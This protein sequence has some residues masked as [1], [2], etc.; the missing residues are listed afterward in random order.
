MERR[1]RNRR[2]RWPPEARVAWRFTPAA[3]LEDARVVSRARRAGTPAGG[4]F[5]LVFNGEARA[6]RAERRAPRA[7]R[8]GGGAASRRG[9]ARAETSATLPSGN[10][11]RDDVSSP[12]PFS[13]SAALD[14]ATRAT[15]AEAKRVA[16][17]MRLDFGDARSVT[18]D[19]RLGDASAADPPE[20]VLVL[21]RYWRSAALGVGAHFLFNFSA[22]VVPETD[23]RGCSRWCERSSAKTRTARAP[24]RRCRARCRGGVRGSARTRSRTRPRLGTRYGAFASRGDSVRGDEGRRDGGAGTARTH[25]ARR[26]FRLVPARRGFRAVRVPDR[27]GPRGVRVARARPAPRGVQERG[28]RRTA[29]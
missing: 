7:R 15:L 24:P 10:F 25:V 29:R 27:R 13:F 22:E 19:A 21:D 18:E 6:R 26:R 17:A 9:R 12:K 16:G 3:S 8:L 11:L 5:D 14:P 2:R 28:P 4:E 20:R 1:F 23:K